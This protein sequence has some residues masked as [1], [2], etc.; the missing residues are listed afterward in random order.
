MPKLHV[1]ESHASLIF[2][3]YCVTGG[4]VDA[5]IVVEPMVVESGV[6]AVVESGV[7]AVV[8][9]G[10]A[11]VVESGV[12]AVVESGGG[13]GG[14][15]AGDAGDAGDVSVVVGAFETNRTVMTIAHDP[16]TVKKVNGPE[17][18]AMATDLRGIVHPW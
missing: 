6:A 12:A 7:A 10:V 1:K 17:T 9:S 2:H 11:A 15:G 3:E 4:G 5:G 18:I 16:V 13:G 14:A 8:E